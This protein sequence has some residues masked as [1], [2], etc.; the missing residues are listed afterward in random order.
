[1]PD[2]PFEAI[3]TNR[4]TVDTHEA[5]VSARRDMK[6]GEVIK[7]LSGIQVA[8]TKEEEKN[9]DLT[10]RDFSIV[11]SSRKK[12]PSLFLG[13]ARFANHDCNANAKLSTVGARGMQVVAITDID[14]GDEITVSY[15]TDY[16]GEDNCECLCS[17]CE[18][19]L[20][21]GW[22]QKDGDSDNEDEPVQTEETEM[23][24]TYSLRGKRKFL[25]DS[26]SLSRASTPENHDRA[27]RRKIQPS[28]LRDV[29]PTTPRGRRSMREVDIKIERMASRTVNDISSIA[30]R[31]NVIKAQ[32][33]DPIESPKFGRR[34]TRAR[35]PRDSSDDSD[36]SRTSSAASSTTQSLQSSLSTA[37]TS[38][39]DGETIVVKRS[40]PTKDTGFASGSATE[41]SVSVAATVAI[42]PSIK[43]ALRGPDDLHSDLSALSEFEVDERSRQAIRRKKTGVI[44]KRCQR[45]LQALLKATQEEDDDDDDDEEETHAV[46]T[47]EVEV[48]MTRRPGDYTLTPLLLSSKYS[49]WVSCNTCDA[50]FVQADAYLTRKECPRCE[51]HSK[52]YGY[53]WPKTD[54]EGKHDTEERIMDHRT[55]HRFVRPEEEKAIKKGRRSMRQDLLKRR[56][57]VESERGRG[58][59]ESTEVESPRRGL[60]KKRA[61]QTM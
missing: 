3:T 22:A 2:C 4:Y 15:G 11:M 32:I 30:V 18:K 36:H 37:A 5:A 61:R 1:M 58:R 54:R 28:K 43:S 33:P 45:E 48:T 38:N 7:Y 35:L 23:E 14:V 21:N 55:V 60:R 50:D 40:A 17:A 10:R 41:L 59:T 13:P 9:L 51:R 53:A 47:T 25:S 31:K 12:T 49:R 20:R 44:K 39:D 56:L 34:K 19:L 46:I 52:L 8:M 27:K 57:S 16:F 6:K 42:A 29:T 24:R 26:E